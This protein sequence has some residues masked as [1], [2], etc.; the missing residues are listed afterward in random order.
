L[1]TYVYHKLKGKKA[2]L[3]S[4]P[5]Y[6]DGEKNCGQKKLGKFGFS[7]LVVLSLNNSDKSCLWKWPGSERKII[8]MTV[9]CIIP[10]PP[11][12]HDKVNISSGNKVDLKKMLYSC[13]K[14]TIS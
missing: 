12:L 4:T 7:F 13:C 8:C 2:L 3:F 11:G 1:P 10:R 6:N 5:S 9:I 14:Q